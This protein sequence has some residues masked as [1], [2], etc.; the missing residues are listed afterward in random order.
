MRRIFSLVLVACALL[1]LAL[2]AGCGTLKIDMP[3]LPTDLP[4]GTFS[5][6]ATPGP[7]T[8]STPEPP[9][10][11]PPSPSPTPTAEPEPEPTPAPTP[12]PLS[13]IPPPLPETSDA[14]DGG[15]GPAISI[16]DYT[17]PED[18][19]EYNVQDLLGWIE[20]DEGI[21]TEVTGTLMNSAG[22]TVQ[23]CTYYPCSWQFSL[24]GTIN[25]ALTFSS[26]TPDIYN[27]SV[28]VTAE[29][30]RVSE[31]VVLDRSFRVYPHNSVLPHR[32]D[33]S[34]YS[35]KLTDDD[36][37]AGRI[38]NFLIAEFDNPYAAA[39]IMGNMYAE[40]GCHPQRLQGDLEEDCSASQRYTEL[41][42][43]GVISRE[44]FIE[45]YSAEG[46]GPGY[47]LCQWSGDRRGTL[48]DMAKALGASVGDA[49]TQ[50]FVVVYELTYLY[51]DLME[52]LRGA[53]AI[54]TATM[55][56]CNIY[57]QPA[58]RTGRSAF[59]LK[60]LEEYAA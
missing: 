29:S 2:S 14:V 44:A 21:I 59:A 55:D 45:G 50:C 13:L 1:T 8:P 12:D 15:G 32:D 33:G 24:A 9:V 16:R 53:G 31:K 25:A 3:P 30:D 34:A 35:A 47:G 18:M 52:S 42:D 20:V 38:W 19:L 22:D 48:Y 23:S 39:A 36:S 10:P 41:V 5:D 46:Y 49:E 28:T 26:L 58:H 17:L 54:S 7:E 43:S 40:S 4:E 57:E 11:L 51:P 27:Y 56:F 6:L 37:T 60:Y